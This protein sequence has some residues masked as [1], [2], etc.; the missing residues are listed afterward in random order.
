MDAGRASKLGRLGAGV[1]SLLI[2]SGATSFAQTPSPVYP[3]CAVPPT[4]FRNVWRIDPVNGQTA[5]AMTAA[6]IPMPAIGAKATA[7]TQGS[8]QHPWNSLQ[9]VFNPPAA[10]G[11]SYPLLTTAPYR[12]VVGSAYQ[13]VAGPLAGPIQP[14]DEILLMS[15]KYGAVTVGYGPIPGVNNPN[16]VTVAAAPGQTPVLTSL[17]VFNSSMLR[18]VGLKVQ[19][20]FPALNYNN[21]IT[22]ADGGGGALVTHDIVF[23]D[24]SVSNAD[25]AV[26]ETWAQAQWQYGSVGFVAHGTNEGANTSCIALL[27]SH[28][29]ALHED[30]V[31]TSR[32]STCSYNELDHYT[33]NAITY[34]SNNL[35]IRG[36]YIHDPIDVGL[37]YHMDAMQGE[38]Q[39]LAAGHKSLT[40]NNVIIDSNIIVEHNDPKNQWLQQTNGIDDYSGV[41]YLTWNNLQVTNNLY[42]GSSVNGILFAGIANSLIGD[43]ILINNDY[44]PRTPPPDI[45]LAPSPLNSNVRLCNN[46]APIIVARTDQGVSLD[47]NI[48]TTLFAYWIQNRDGTF[49]KNSTW[50]RRPGFYGASGGPQPMRSAAFSNE[51]MLHAEPR[52]LHSL[53]LP[54]DT[55]AWLRRARLCGARLCGISAEHAASEAGPCSIENEAPTFDFERGPSGNPD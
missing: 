36:N 32:N 14:G 4:A 2:L 29:Y 15:G 35:L 47:H 40:W 23:S 34:G 16:F 26:Y 54:G 52:L 24:M 9:A 41:P 7:A 3:G 22:V 31:C 19:A 20:L 6:G 1:V 43:N 25:P 53:N 48:A 39:P 44:A 33:D 50:F 12:H 17:N 18:F 55:A 27:D 49:A 51:V 46:I 13:T 45:N 38:G 37:S 5:E 28:V 42:I 8:P 21:L 10:S 30:I 11:Y